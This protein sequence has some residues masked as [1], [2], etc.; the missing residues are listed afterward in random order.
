ME[1]EEMF[2]SITAPT[3]HSSVDFTVH[4]WLKKYNATSLRPVDFREYW[5]L[6]V[7]NIYSPRAD[8][9]CL[10]MTFDEELAKQVL[11]TPLERFVCGCNDT[12]GVFEELKKIDNPPVLCGHVFKSEEPT[13]SCRDCG[14]DPTCVLC[15]ECFKNSSHKNHRYKMS[16]NGGGGYCD[17]GDE[18]AW[19]A[20][21]YCEMHLQ[22]KQ[23]M[24]AQSSPIEQIPLDLI[25]RVRLI[26]EVVL[27]YCH[28][29][30]SWEHPISPPPDL[31]PPG[32]RTTNESQDIY[33]TMLFNDEIHTYDQVIHTLSRA[34]ECSEKEATDCASTID[35]EGRRIVKCGT[36]DKCD[37]VRKIIERTTSRS[38][39]KPLRVVVM[40]SSVIAHQI[41][42]MR[43]LL[44][45]K[46]MLSYSKA[47][48]VIFS[49]VMM[50]SPTTDFP[51]L[52][53]II[54]SDTQLWKAARN[55]WHQLF[56]SGTLMDQQSK[57]TFARIFTHNYP[58][59]MKDFIAD[60]HEHSVSITSLSVQI[61]TVP[62]LARYLIMEED[63]I[64]VLLRTF[65]TE[66]ERNRKDGKLCF[67]RGQN[68]EMFRRSQY[69]L[70]DLRFLL[71][72]KPKDWNSSL[73]KNFLHGIQQLLNFL[74]WM[75]GMDSVI[76]QVGQH[77]EFE[78]EWET[79]IN[80]QLKLVPLITLVLDWCGSDRV[81]LVKALRA[82][83]KLLETI[84]EKMT[85]IGQEVAD[86][87]ASCIECDISSMPVT[88]HLPL[89]RFVA[90][91][92][93][94]L[95][96]Y[97]L[98]YNSPEFLIGNKPGPE[99][100]MEPP[101]R[102]Q[103][104]IAQ[105]R[106]GMWRRN[107]YSLVN[108]VSFYH[109]VRLR[110]EMLDR[111]IMLLQIAASLIESNEFVI[112]LLNKYGLLIWVGDTF[113]TS[114]RSED[115]YTRQTAAIAEEFLSLLITII[116][117]RYYPGIG[118]VTER[119]K[120][121]KEIIQLLC[122]E[123]MPHSQLCK[124]L[125]RDSNH[126]TGIED[127]MTEVA[128]LKKPTD[129][130]TGK[131]E[132]KPEFYSCFNPFFYHYTR[133]EQSKAEEVQL[134]RK[135]QAG[136]EECCPPPL[137]P[138]FT[139][140]FSIIINIL[141]CDVIVHIT[142]LVLK[143][144]SNLHSTAYS[145]GQLEKILHLIG[146]ALHEEQRQQ[147][148][149]EENGFFRYTEIAEKKGILANL[150]SCQGFPRVE[151]HKYL[152][153]WTLRKFHALQRQK[154]EGKA[155]VTDVEPLPESTASTNSKRDKKQSAQQAAARRARIMAQMSA[156]QKSFIRQH[157]ELLKEV[158]SEE[159]SN[160]IEYETFVVEEGSDDPVALG[161][162]QRGRMIYRQIYT[163]ILCRE[164][165]EATLTGR[166]LVIGA[167]VQRSTVLSK[168]RN[169][170]FENPKE[171]NPL[172]I[173]ADLSCGPHTSTCGHVM[174][175]VCWKKFFEA[176]VA[177]ERRR[178]VRYGRHVS[179]NVDKQEFLCPLCGCLSNTVIP[180]MPPNT[181]FLTNTVTETKSIKMDNWLF[182]LQKA[183]EK[184]QVQRLRAPLSEDESGEK[185]L[186][187][188]KPTSLQ[189]VMSYFS[190]DVSEQLHSLFSVYLQQHTLCNSFPDSLLDMIKVFCQA[191]Y[192]VGLNVHPHSD[193]ER[194]PL[195]AWWS[196]AYTIHSIDQL[197]QDQKKSLFGDLS[198][199][200][201]QCI[202]S[203]V[204]VVGA[205]LRIFDAQV[206]RS[207]CVNLLQF[208]L[209]PEH[210][211]CSPNCCLEVDAFTLL[212]FGCLSM[213][214]LFTA[215][216]NH[217]SNS[218][219]AFPLGGDNELCMLHL[220]LV[221][222][223]VQILL[224]IDFPTLEETETSESQHKET[225]EEVEICCFYFEVLNETGL[226]NS[227]KSVNVQKLLRNIHQAMLPFL[228]CSALFFHF[229]TD[230]GAPETL[231]EMHG[232]EYQFQALC[233]YLGLSCHLNE[234]VQSSLLRQLAHCW[235]RRARDC[236]LF[237]KEKSQMTEGGDSSP[238]KWVLI[239]YPTVINQLVCL[240]A[241]YSDLINNIS[242][243][244]CPNSNGDDSRSPTLCLV[245][246]QMLCSHSYCCQME[247]EGVVV[248]ACTFHAHICGAGV[249]MFLRIR[250]CEILLLGGKTKGCYM[251][252]PYVDEY[253]ET[254]QG[255]MRGNPLHLC[256][257][258]YRE[259]HRLWLSHGIPEQVSHTLE[260]FPFLATTNWLL[261]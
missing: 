155:M 206:V 9:N 132:L 81:V 200:Q 177:K 193:D 95:S 151:A 178:P 26:M 51:L 253:G 74:S 186:Y 141:Q 122:I 124:M 70:F 240:P 239:K 134:K 32:F 93:L 175:S 257:D 161:N 118:N 172:L 143:R 90:G 103:V 43:L 88:I 196:C 247:L 57:K 92:V 251:A 199:R 156:M 232:E 260:Q 163:C 86:H 75:Q 120:V 99:E 148:S 192:T 115:E 224:S 194:V 188:Y 22:G 152:L 147:E 252:P 149:K 68:I 38:G 66:C 213:P 45:L 209:L 69:V 198:S 138:E 28:E 160:Q 228:R 54:L 169:H 215:S 219:L 207:H 238:R 83:L 216:N 82:A 104:M 37:E 60:D 245:C 41:F 3:F 174:H 89:S 170:I 201:A 113:D 4:D 126:E 231:Q 12:Y 100:L 94:H 102:T 117:E 166:T 185:F 259:L 111:D 10:N 40:H 226:E 50:E 129:T 14:L 5:A 222:H 116:S 227:R 182:G 171:F 179:Y 153:N 146:L 159:S 123:S 8:V 121:K 112:H 64:Y 168:V 77:I 49:Q 36:F 249:G 30:L 52:E 85:A 106:A 136:E 212:V 244:T 20:Y 63:A 67:E 71:T 154:K 65:L 221:F 1:D 140:P 125:P 204:R 55:Q 158:D 164:E 34:I 242:M 48:H 220:I 183:V 91:L 72:V 137:P 15:M 61:F 133:E 53:S 233:R 39:R 62:T 165:Q 214:A 11:F 261:M 205:S 31:C 144:A 145:E 87:S 218:G 73:R 255:L 248:G 258:R 58:L 208:L 211:S 237:T 223:L 202:Q 234:V 19:K 167:F 131:Y 97:D 2:L 162:L 46:Q 13:Y 80:L 187:R 181:T 210:H 139:P 197:L 109:N 78:A 42:S 243:F 18:E 16:M 105:F 130:S 101:L 256:K 184:L 119:D 217:G 246:G 173:S 27:S 180:L 250:N 135:K 142:N 23:M 191:T 84:Q 33:A 56:I 79:G 21:A 98:M 150:E 114:R 47:F 241:D 225:P 24:S 44:W 110:E 59:L 17:C 128:G 25:Q 236:C 176:V 195:M 230:V 6:N 127:V 203:L 157:A 254:D 76:R 229:L 107:G 96:K 190:A 29:M 35:R 235:A 108:Q 7:P 189:E